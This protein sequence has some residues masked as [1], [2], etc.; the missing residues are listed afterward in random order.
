MLVKAPFGALVNALEGHAHGVA[1]TEVG[2]RDGPMMQ[3]PGAPSGPP[4]AEFLCVP[5]P[6]SSLLLWLPFHLFPP[7]YGTA[8]SYFYEPVCILSN[9]LY[10]QFKLYSQ[11]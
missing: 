3:L 5:S 11:G 7:Q 4:H 1:H 2:G 9:I 10:S 6:F 8:F